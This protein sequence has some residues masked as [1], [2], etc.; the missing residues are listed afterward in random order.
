MGWIISESMSKLQISVVDKVLLMKFRRLHIYIHVYKDLLISKF[1]ALKQ[2]ILVPL[3][4]RQPESNNIIMNWLFF[5][6]Q[7]WNGYRVV[8]LATKLGCSLG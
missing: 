7:P 2:I 5:T 1:S 6:L 3:R 8:R 4:M